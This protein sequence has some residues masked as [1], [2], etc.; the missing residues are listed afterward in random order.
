MSS[1]NHPHHPHPHSNPREG[2]SGDPLDALRRRTQRGIIVCG[3]LVLLAAA[4]C[5]WPVSIEPLQAPSQ[6]AADQAAIAARPNLPPLDI[7]PFDAP[8]WLAPPAPPP[9]EVAAKPT[10]PPPPLRLELLGIVRENDAY[11]A[12]VYDPDTDKV[13]VLASGDTLAGRTVGNIT[14]VTVAIRDGAGIRTLTLKNTSP[15]TGPGGG[16]G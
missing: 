5:F 16:D 1:S 4:F 14:A 13:T 12:V 7:A 8:V 10:P 11:K 2:N 3:G 15:P 9:V 6:P